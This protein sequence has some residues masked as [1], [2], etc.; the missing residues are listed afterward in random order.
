MNMVLEQLL[1]IK[2]TMD[3]FQRNLVLNANIASQKNEAQA[4]E[5]LK[6]VEVHYAAMIKE[7]EACQAIHACALEKSH[8]ESM[9]ELE[10]EVIE[11]DG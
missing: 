1:M 8:K 11:E 6:Q 5:A 9:L 10:C 7:V 4:T 3:S 2:A